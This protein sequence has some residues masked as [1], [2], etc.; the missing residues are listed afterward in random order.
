MPSCLMLSL[1]IIAVP[2]AVFTSVVVFAAMKDAVERIKVPSVR[3]RLLPLRIA[4]VCAVAAIVAVIATSI[5]F[6]W[7]HAKPCG[8]AASAAL[9]APSSSVC[10]MASSFVRR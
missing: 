7:T 4:P 10:V 6:G 3:W 8:R 1:T 9:T 2:L 5:G